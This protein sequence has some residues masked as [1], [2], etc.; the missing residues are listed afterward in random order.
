[1]HAGPARARARARASAPAPAAACAL[2]VAVVLALTFAL[3]G[4]AAAEE[5]PA[6]S[7]GDFFEVRDRIGEPGGTTQD[8]VFRQTVDALE[9][10]ALQ[11]TSHR[12]VRMRGEFVAPVF[13]G[14]PG[15]EYGLVTW[16]RAT[17][18]AEMRWESGGSGAREVREYAE[19]CVSMRFPLV[20]GETW[21][22]RCVATITT[23]RAGS[24]PTTFVETR[25]TTY[26]VLGME[27]VTVPAGTFSAYV[28]ESNTTEN[29]FD[30]Q[31]ARHWF[32]PAACT[33]VKTVSVQSGGYSDTYELLS[34]RCASTG[35]EG[36]DAGRG[37]PLSAWSA[38]LAMLAAAALAAPFALAAGRRRQ[39]P[40]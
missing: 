9:D 28:L 17:D 16:T 37:L 6:L 32:A 20:V 2:W 23:T 36:P 26:R 34:Y 14:E 18:G 10:V 4:V 40:R 22:S 15:G 25:T 7:V 38:P 35:H 5:G 31:P 30:I 21:T 11:G 8:R 3:V 1:M 13:T 12:A 29:P 24:E 19:P 33:M 39:P 27:E